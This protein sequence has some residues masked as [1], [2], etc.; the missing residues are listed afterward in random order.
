[1][2]IQ[3]VRDHLLQSQRVCVFTG[4][5]LLVASGIP[6]FRSEDGLWKRWPTKRHGTLNAFLERPEEVG[7]YLGSA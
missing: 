7:V 2:S 6:D 5:G 4:A 1:M 3:L